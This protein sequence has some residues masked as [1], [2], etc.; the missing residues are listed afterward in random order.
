M[1]ALLW[2]GFFIAA[3]F[4]AP[5]Q[6]PVG[7]DGAYLALD[8]TLYR[9]R[10]GEVLRSAVGRPVL[11]V[12]S[13]GGIE[14]APVRAGEAFALFDRATGAGPLALELVD[15]GGLSFT[16]DRE[17][18]QAYT[19]FLFQAGPG[20]TLDP[21]GDYE[22][23]I[24]Y[25]ALKSWGEADEDEEGRPLPRRLALEEP[26]RVTVRPLP[27]GSRVDNLGRVVPDEDPLPRLGAPAPRKGLAGFLGDL[28]LE[29][30]PELAEDSGELG[31]T[32]RATYAVD[33]RRFGAAH[34]GTFSVDFA[35]D[36]RWSTQ[37]SDPSLRGWARGELSARAMWLLGSERYYPVGA[38]LAAGYEGRE[39]GR[40]A[41]GT[42]RGELFAALPYLGDVLSGWQ[43]AL[44]FERAFAPP[45]IG[46]AYVGSGAEVGSDPQDR[47]EV[48]AGWRAPIAR[49]WDL[50][51]RWRHFDFTRGG[52]AEEQLF[53]GSFLFFPT[54]DPSQGLRLSFEEGYRAAV[55]DIGS[56]FL[57]GYSVSL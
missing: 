16:T 12:T 49:R 9:E 46:V 22:L 56:A 10:D 36:G 30:T 37:E 33:R 39:G 53:E 57:V 24:H 4:P 2:L 20:E 8:Y 25:E 3:A 1:W 38:R 31:L 55:G 45:F 44:G 47:I 51:L 40:G 21:R 11:I 42:L 52:V 17:G 19:W 34:P 27:P 54:G 6:E 23:V 7:R 48:E 32:Y 29:L 13:A 50:D 35:L 41:G 14:L 5:A 18:E 43:D 26:V 28:S 15:V